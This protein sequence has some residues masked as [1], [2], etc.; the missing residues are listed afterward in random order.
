[1]V[2][3]IGITKLSLF[4]PCSKIVMLFSVLWENNPI[5]LISLQKQRSVPWLHN[6]LVCVQ[7]PNNSK[8][9]LHQLFSA[10]AWV[11]KGFGDYESKMCARFCSVNGVRSFLTNRRQSALRHRLL[12]H[13]PN[14]ATLVLPTLR[15]GFFHHKLSFCLFPAC[16][17]VV[18]NS[19][20]CLL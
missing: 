3:Q 13:K 9:E 15:R 1:M 7:F 12:Q 10:H 20:V 6:H 16:H 4:L 8:Q 11:T 19:C 5:Q 14:A 18:I 17:W 2:G